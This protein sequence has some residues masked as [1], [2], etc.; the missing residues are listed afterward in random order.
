MKATRKA[1]LRPEKREKK[2]KQASRTNSSS[3]VGRK[4]EKEP[5]DDD[6]DSSDDD[7]SGR[8]RSPR[9]SGGS[10]PALTASYPS[11][12]KASGDNM[13]AVPS[14]SLSK[15]KRTIS[16]CGRGELA[17]QDE[18]QDRGL[19]AL[20]RSQDDSDIVTRSRSPVSPRESMR[21][22]TSRAQADE[23]E[24]SSS[25]TESLG[26]G[27]L[28]RGS[29]DVGDMSHIHLPPSFTDLSRVER[30]SVNVVH[31][32]YNPRSGNK[33]GEKVMRKAR[34]LL[35]EKY[36]KTVHVT[37]LQYKGHAEELC[38]TMSLDGIDILCSVGGDGTFH[39]CTN[40]IMKRMLADGAA[41]IPPMALIAAGT[42]N[43]FMH[44]LGYAKLKD[45]VHHICRGM[46]VPIDIG[47][48]T[49]GDGT[50]CYSFNS[51]HWGMASKVA[52]TAE[53]LR[54]MGTA[55][56]YT[57]AALIEMMKGKTARAR[58]TITDADDNVITY[59]EEFALAIAN[60]IITAG[61]GMKMAPTAKLD[62]GL[63]DLLLI[64]TAST[65]DMM[66]IFR[67]VYDGSHT[68]EELLDRAVSNHQRGQAGT[69]E[70]EQV[71]QQVDRAALHP[72][73]GQQQQ[74][75]QEEGRRRQERQGGR[76]RA[77]G[78]Q[79]KEKGEGGQASA[80]EE[81]GSSGH[82][83]IEEI[84]E[85][86]DVDGELKGCTPFTCDVIPRALRVIL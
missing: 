33:A 2:Q 72:A 11:D 81:S 28:S 16:S 60:N 25:D 47:K 74:Q 20:K 46:H 1:S 85:L 63:I 34:K 15:R 3:A 55:I 49:F 68:S 64:T 65:L 57:T 79:E 30:V 26:E 62:D 69:G 9:V 27:D 44:E 18:I 77:E 24:S 29:S 54:W 39:E 37:K 82:G 73:G 76:G 78:E 5:G 31:L 17:G 35:E 51:M 71:G 13:L 67:K 75:Q 50:S 58:I 84:E 42:G 83:T 23:I 70:A 48:L 41:R 40:G 52:V 80:A 86:L 43:S 36:G 10:G 61:K 6:G 4:K 21:P 7:L 14:L 45:A 66:T 32:L 8:L 59:D 19:N 53:K 56:R 12:K 38:E 22:L